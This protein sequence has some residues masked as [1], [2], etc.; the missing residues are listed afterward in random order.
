MRPLLVVL[1]A[2]F[3]V[4]THAQSVANE[5]LRFTN[6]TGT[7]E[8]TYSSF[9]CWRVVPTIGAARQAT[10]VYIYFNNFTLGSNFHLA[11]YEGDSTDSTLYGDFYGDSNPIPSG[12][13]VVVDTNQ[14]LVVLNGDGGNVSFSFHYQ[15]G[16]DTELKT[17]IIVL[18]STIIILC[19]PLICVRAAMCTETKKIKQ[20][21]LTHPEFGTRRRLVTLWLGIILGFLIAVL[22]LSRKL[23]M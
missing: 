12:S 11:I 23:V 22:L 18:V 1:L 10:T 4:S 9:A 20:K 5:C 19:A 7:I 14:L 3:A 13:P 6:L 8:G 15:A 16:S 21:Q 17:A 2:L